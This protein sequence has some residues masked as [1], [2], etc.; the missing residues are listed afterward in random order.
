VFDAIEKGL[1][2]V[3]SFM[4]EGDVEAHCQLRSP[5]TDDTLMTVADDLV[6][7]IEIKGARKLIGDSE[8]EVMAANMSRILSGVMKS[9]NGA[10]HSF[11][12]A[13]R[14]SPGSAP[15]LLREILEP[16]VRTAKRYGASQ[17]DLFIDQV[18]SLAAR[19]SEE[20]AYMLMYT[21]P[22]GLSPADRKRLDAWR[23][24]T[25][26][27]FAKAAP[28]MRTGDDFTQ[29]PKAPPPALVPRHAAALGNLIKDLE[30][31]IEKGGAGLL[32]ELLD[33]GAGLS[34]MRR[35]LDASPFDSSWR[36][37]LIG[38]RSAAAPGVATRSRD[39]SHMFPMRIG[40]QLVSEPAKEIFGDVEMAKRGATYYGGIV[41][42]VPPE[43]GSLPFAEL[44]ARISREIPWTANIEMVP[45]GEKLRKMDQFYAGFVGAF[46]DYNK[47]VKA[48]WKELRDLKNTGVYI[49]AIRVTFCTWGTTEEEVIQNVSFLKSSIESWGSCVATNETGSPGLTALCAAAGYSRRMP[50]PYLPGPINDYARMLPLFRPASVWDNGQLL[51]HT[52]EGRP[53]PVAFGS[54]KQNYWGT[55][56]FAPT[57]TGK[58]FLMNMINFGILMSPGLDELPYLTVVDVGPSSRLVL[59]LVRAMLPERLAR[60]VVSIRVRNSLEFAVNPFDTQL[61]CDRPTEVDKDFQVAVVST[62][63]PTLGL[64]GER[65]IGQVIN[66]AYKMMGRNSPAQRRWQ[67][68]LDEKVSADLVQIGYQV[69]ETTRVWDVVDALFSAG[70][71]D[72]AARAQRYAVPRLADLVKASRAKEILDSY[73]SAPT[74]SGELLLDVF[75]RNIQTALAEFELIA[76]Y[77]R[78]EL[79]NARAVSIDLEE[80]VTGNESEEG[81]RR[82]AMM[83]LFGRRLGAKNYFLRWDEIDAIVPP[84]YR[85]Y[86]H[87]RIERLQEAMKFLEYDEVH[88]ASGI[89]SMSKR[90]QEDLRV[91]RK[92]KCVTMMSSQLLADFP[93]AAVD[94]CYTYFVL[95]VG[96]GNSADALQKTFSLSPSEVMAIQTECTGPGRLLGLFKTVKGTTSQVLHTTA[97]PLMRWAFSTVKDDALLRTALTDALGGQYL[98]ALRLLAATFPQGT[99]RDEMERYSRARG[100]TT[101]GDS[102][103]EIFTRKVLERAAGV[104]APA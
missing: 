4:L 46:G 67:G 47:R 91:G 54:T 53:Y 2:W 87:Q 59:D 40:R 21:H 6:S 90:L 69:S 34:R 74:P 17:L 37:R 24:E 104:K 10:Q 88:Y 63:C 82:A 76:G 19:C 68:S 70:R 65:F 18:K 79:G 57:G 26:D 100:A 16:S 44:A 102:M 30:L 29:R 77:T 96:T 8:F 15:R 39:A 61:G 56:I 62:L 25:G 35:H 12:F 85:E 5:L 94:N 28:G 14:S 3:S 73:G 51:A 11:A 71:I 23:E 101:S 36:P 72:D 42:E 80:V 50:G 33:V 89:P 9:A 64:E 99:A 60:Q 78:F 95:G 97:G 27:K 55:L 49:T 20:S 13:F 22:S 103:T 86:Q 32:L 1:Y 43:S 92:Y 84:L 48:G 38:D 58:S 7:I 66:E 45:N 98:E 81:K 93:A 75:T 52:K 41:L 83:F 31:D